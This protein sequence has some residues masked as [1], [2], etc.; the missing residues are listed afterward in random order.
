MAVTANRFAAISGRRGARRASADGFTLTEMLV[1]VALIAIGSAVAIPVTMQMVN[2]AKN[3][4]SAL[5][6][7]TFID[8]ARD[9]AV[10]ERRNIEMTFT[11]PNRIILNR[12]EVPSGARTQVGE[13]RLEGAQEFIK[14]PGVATD[15]PDLFGTGCCGAVSFTG[16]QPVMF[17]SDGSLID[18][19]GDVVNGTVFVGVPNRPESARAIAVFGMTGMLRTWNWRGAQWMQ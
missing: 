18:A 11:M 19:N 12:I 1:V 6:A 9:K 4:S 16:T 8:S 5:V 7:Q 15:T 13:I 14:L 10:A 3:D 2:R 17:T